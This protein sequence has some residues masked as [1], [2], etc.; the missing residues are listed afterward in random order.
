MNFYLPGVEVIRYALLSDKVPDAG[1]IS[2]FGFYV[3]KD[4][5]GVALRN[6]SYLRDVKWDYVEQS[7]G[8]GMVNFPV[9]EYTEDTSADEISYDTIFL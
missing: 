9:S 6:Q 3:Y 1:Y 5:T 8:Y 2:G 7:Y 4:G